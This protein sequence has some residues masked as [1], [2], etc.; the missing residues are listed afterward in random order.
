MPR[1]LFVLSLASVLLLGAGAVLLQ[2]PVLTLLSLVLLISLPAAW[3]R[4][5]IARRASRELESG[6]SR[7][8]CIRAI[9]RA[10]EKGVRNARDAWSTRFQ[11]AKGLL[12]QL[13]AP[14]ARFATLLFGTLIYGGTLL[15]P[16]ALPMGA[17]VLPARVGLDSPAQGD[18]A[19]LIRRAE[20]PTQRLELL[21]EAARAEAKAGRQKKAVSY[22]QRAEKTIQSVKKP[23]RK[24][25]RVRLMTVRASLEEPKCAAKR[26]EKALGI[27]VELV[28]KR[29]RVL[30]RALNHVVPQPAAT[31][32]NLSLAS[33]QVRELL[34]RAQRMAEQR[35]RPEPAAALIESARVRLWTRLGRAERLLESARPLLTRGKLPKTVQFRVRVALQSALDGLD[36]DEKRTQGRRLAELILGRLDEAAAPW[37]DALA[38]DCHTRLG[39]WAVLRGDIEPAREHFQAALRRREAFAKGEARRG[40]RLMVLDLAWAEWQTGDPGAARD[41]LRNYRERISSY[42]AIEQFLPAANARGASANRRHPSWQQRRG[43]AHEDLYELIR[44]DE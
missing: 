38:A 19:Q 4:G 30:A 41:R 1:M 21:L 16:V 23:E 44:S 33:R 17:R 11:L 8:D 13:H 7:A 24:P 34:D 12:E 18:W 22:L 26:L 27:A 2:D 36:Q 20:G 35:S 42:D 6:A 31:N 40:G 28:D 15:A 14:P 37:R 25:F 32:Q 9:M 5:S 39:W 29:P 3:R 10:M 43:E